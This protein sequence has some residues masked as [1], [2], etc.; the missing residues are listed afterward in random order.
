[1]SSTSLSAPMFLPNTLISPDVGLN[2]PMTC[3]MITLL[4]EPD[5]PISTVIFFG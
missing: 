2:S 5:A 4:P 1:L 3:L